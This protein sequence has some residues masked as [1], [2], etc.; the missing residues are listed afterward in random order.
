MPTL[1]KI[2]RA[3]TQRTSRHELQHILFCPTAPKDQHYY[4]LSENKQRIN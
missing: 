4:S 2:K 1:R 3:A